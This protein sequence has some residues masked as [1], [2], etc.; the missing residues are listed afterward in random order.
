MAVADLT[1]LLDGIEHAPDEWLRST[2]A[3]LQQ[4]QQA[5]IVCRGERWELAAMQDDAARVAD[6]LLLELG[7]RVRQQW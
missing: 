2:L 5:D 6:K 3:H 4:I 7:R 1:V